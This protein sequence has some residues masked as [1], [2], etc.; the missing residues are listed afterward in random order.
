MR[1]LYAKV[2]HVG[3]AVCRLLCDP[4]PAVWGSAARELAPLIRDQSISVRQG[5]FRQ[6]RRE[7]VGA[8]PSLRPDADVDRLRLLGDRR[9]SPHDL[10]E[11]YPPVH[12]STPCGAPSRGLPPRVLQLRTP[13]TGRARGV[14][15]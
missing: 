3:A 9:L 14:H 8:V 5:R 12:D 15:S 6:E 2:L 1:N 13:M 4:Q 10:L 11:G 7:A